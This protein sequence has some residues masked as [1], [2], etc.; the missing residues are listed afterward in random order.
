V[1]GQYTAV[2]AMCLVCC[3]RWWWLRILFM[4][5]SFLHWSLLLIQAVRQSTCY[6]STRLTTGTCRFYSLFFTF[7]T[8]SFG[9][10]ATLTVEGDDE[11]VGF[12]DVSTRITNKSTLYI[13]NPRPYQSGLAVHPDHRTKGIAKV[14][15]NIN[16]NESYVLIGGRL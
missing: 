1:I 9:T 2:K 4:T 11:V 14:F 13:Y 15:K 5:S 16:R 6:A 10:L 12:C 7:E 3:W 8:A